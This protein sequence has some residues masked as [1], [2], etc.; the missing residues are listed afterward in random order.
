MD[1]RISFTTIV[2][3]FLQ[4]NPAILSMMVEVI[5]SI[6]DELEDPSNRRSLVVAN[7]TP[8]QVYLRVGNM[9]LDHIGHNDDKVKYECAMGRGNTLV[10]EVITFLNEHPM[11]NPPIPSSRQAPPPSRRAL[12]PPS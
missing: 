6:A 2:R 4:R 10:H 12:P 11:P 7:I 5:H 9:V 3:Q 8:R 1:E